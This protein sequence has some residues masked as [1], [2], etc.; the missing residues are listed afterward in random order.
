MQKML[1]SWQEN[2]KQL[3]IRFLDF[4]LSN[5]YISYILQNKSQAFCPLKLSDIHRSVSPILLVGRDYEQTGW[6]VQASQKAGFPNNPFKLLAQEEPVATPS[7]LQN[8]LQQNDH[9]LNDGLSLRELNI[10]LIQGHKTDLVIL[11]PLPWSLSLQESQMS[12]SLI[13]Q[14]RLKSVFQGFC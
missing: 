12:F 4:H 6:K 11:Q 14:Y 2:S 10:G 8:N 5:F 13:L 3:R 9:H 1:K 7:T